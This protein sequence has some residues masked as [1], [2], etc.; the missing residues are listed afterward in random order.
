MLFGFLKTCV[1]RTRLMV[2]GRN[3]EH[4]SVHVFTL[5]D[6]KKNL[7][8]VFFAISKSSF[9]PLYDVALSI[10]TFLTFRE[11]ISVP[12]GIIRDC[13]SSYRPDSLN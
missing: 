5:L 1:D 4:P 7:Y 10:A 2:T 12:K 9:F 13:D 11:F 6:N 8:V 3:L